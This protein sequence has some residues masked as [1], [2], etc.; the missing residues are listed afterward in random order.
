MNSENRGKSD[1][2]INLQSV[3]AEHH[4]LSARAAVIMFIDVII[5]LVFFFFFFFSKN[6]RMLLKFI[7]RYHNYNDISTVLNIGTME[8]RKGHDIFPFLSFIRPFELKTNHS[9]E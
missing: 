4:D 6:C 2:P 7:G 9:N 1:K 5:F 8:P 3:R